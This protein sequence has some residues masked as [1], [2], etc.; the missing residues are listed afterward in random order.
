MRN[1]RPEPPSHLPRS[2]PPAS[3]LTSPAAGGRW[4]PQRPPPHLARPFSPSGIQS[5]VRPATRRH[6]NGR[7][8]RKRA[9][10]EAFTLPTSSTSLPPGLAN[11]RRQAQAPAENELYTSLPSPLSTWGQSQAA[12]LPGST[13]GGRGNRIGRARP[14]AQKPPHGKHLPHRHRLG[15]PPHARTPRHRSRRL[16][17]PHPSPQRPRARPEMA[18]GPSRRPLSTLPGGRGERPSPCRPRRL[19][20]PRDG[21]A[22]GAA[23]GGRRE[24][25]PP[26]SGTLRGRR[27]IPYLSPAGSCAQPPAPPSS[28]AGARHRRGSA[29]LGSPQLGGA[30]RPPHRR[31]ARPA[32]PD[33]AGG[34][35]RRRRGRLLARC[36]RFAPRR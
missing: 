12:A 3:A 29:R 4:T 36:C 30:Q 6:P 26:S 21:T 2:G 15:A 17:P 14:A 8:A 11:H 9:P 32:A 35:G 20:Q 22:P 25:E 13:A 23:E 10:S 34:E 27:A 16:I 5:Y 24:G 33:R 18:A 7:R 19:R 31:T 28:S 1:E